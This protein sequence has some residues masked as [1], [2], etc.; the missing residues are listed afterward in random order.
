[1]KL[2]EIKGEKTLDVIAELIEP[3]ANIVRDKDIDI[4]QRVELPEGEDAKAF[5]AERLIKGVPQLLKNHKR[6]LITILAAVQC[7]EREEYAAQLNLAKLFKDATEI[8]KDEEFIELF[9]SAQSLT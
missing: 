7:V 2:S 8:L 5:T 3:V 6:D 1:M 9:I 4:F